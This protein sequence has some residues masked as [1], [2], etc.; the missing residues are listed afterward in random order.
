MWTGCDPASH[1]QAGHA[2]T[3]PTS[4]MRRGPIRVNDSGVKD[5]NFDDLRI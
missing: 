3:A 2:K 5:G 1:V 4:T